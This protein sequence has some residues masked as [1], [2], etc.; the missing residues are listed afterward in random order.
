[1]SRGAAP[2]TWD[3]VDLGEVATL[4]RGY[5]L[6][7]GQ[8]RPGA[9][10]VV[11]SS[12]ITGFHDEPKCLPPGVVTGRYGTLGEV[13]F[14][15]VPFWP[16]NTALYVSD[17]HDNDARFVSYFL[18]CQGLGSQDGAAA[19]PGVN[20]N[21][22]H[23]MP[24]L[25]PPLLTQRKIAAILSAYDDLIAN[26]RRRARILEEMMQR[27]YQGWFT[28]FKYPGHDRVELVESG[29][30]L[31]PAGWSVQPSANWRPSFVVARIVARRWCPREAC[32]FL[33]SSALHAT[34]G[35]DLKASSASR[36]STGNSTQWLWAT[37]SW[38]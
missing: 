25:R 14:V 17:F 5:D 3:E 28:D 16:L 36:A 21:V 38:P 34:E 19:V 4:H 15:D 37:S 12:G 31:C 24:A 22:L 7:S 9:I 1:M 18:Q 6:P 32:R 27:I 13:F 2:S 30:G 29:L 8:R 10:P 26:H 35:F 11:S 33:T 23:R 20:R